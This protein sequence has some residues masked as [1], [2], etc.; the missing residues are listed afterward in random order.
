M[1]YYA[2]Y[3]TWDEKSILINKSLVRTVEFFELCNFKDKELLQIFIF[4]G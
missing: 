4:S 3:V 2:L 1:L